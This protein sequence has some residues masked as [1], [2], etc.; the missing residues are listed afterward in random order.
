M[1]LFQINTRNT[2]LTG[3][4]GLIFSYEGM[5]RG[6]QFELVCENFTVSHLINP[7]RPTQP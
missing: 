6:I 5:V 1:Y 3:V 2:N 4:L 7:G